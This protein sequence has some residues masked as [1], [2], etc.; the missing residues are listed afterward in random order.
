MNVSILVSGMEL[1]GIF[2]KYFDPWL[3]ESVE[4]ESLVME[5]QL[6]S[7]DQNKS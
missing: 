3:V 6:Y 1:S 5:G 4:V 2:K 7:T